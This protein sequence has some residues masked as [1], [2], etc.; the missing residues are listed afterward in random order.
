MRKI[1]ENTD[2]FYYI[3]LN[4]KNR[5]VGDCVIRALCALPDN[6]WN[7]YKT[8]DELCEIAR[9]KCCTPSNDEAWDKW[10][11][12]HGYVRYPMPRKPNRKLYKLGEFVKSDYIN[13]DESVIVSVSNH[14]TCIVNRKVHDIWDC[15]G[16]T[17]RRYYRKSK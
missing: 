11:A 7:W 1:P 8:F 16:Y 2:T 13:D 5:V 3:N 17:V 10:L 15:T 12:D 9:K 6:A 4:P 14:L